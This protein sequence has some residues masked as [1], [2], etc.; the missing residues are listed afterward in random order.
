MSNI[1]Q[2]TDLIVCWE[3]NWP[4]TVGIDRKNANDE[5]WDFQT[6]TIKKM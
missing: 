6:K 5:F 4:D 3:P 2:I 1:W